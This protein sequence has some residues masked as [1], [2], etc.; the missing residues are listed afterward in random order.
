MITLLT[1][2]E[3]IQQIAASRAGNYYLASW[4]A[5]EEGWDDE[6][7]YKEADMAEESL[8]SALTSISLIYDVNLLD[9]ISDTNQFYSESDSNNPYTQNVVPIALFA[10]QLCLGLRDLRIREIRG[11]LD[12][13]GAEKVGNDGRC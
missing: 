2:E 6:S 7:L 8:R 1:Y 3:A 10:E 11:D 13:C 9:V 12:T 5:Y 4:Y